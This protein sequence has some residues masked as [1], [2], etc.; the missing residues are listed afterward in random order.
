VGPV[1]QLVEVPCPRVVMVIA[2]GRG[3]CLVEGKGMRG[4]LESP[5]SCEMGHRLGGHDAFTL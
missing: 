4:V 3:G 1:M 5:K 2:H